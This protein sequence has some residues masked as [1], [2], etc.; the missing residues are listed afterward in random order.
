MDLDLSV[1]DLN[2]M[3]DSV[4]NVLFSFLEYENSKIV[5]SSGLCYIKVRKTSMKSS[6]HTC[7]FIERPYQKQEVMPYSTM[8]LCFLAR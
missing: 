7:H 4:K 2:P 6:C 5:K 8:L 1:V 3:C